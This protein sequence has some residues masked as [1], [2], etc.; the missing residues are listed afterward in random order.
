MATEVLHLVTQ[1]NQPYGSTRR[2]CEMCGAMCWPGM[3]GSAKRWTD[4]RQRWTAA[5]DNCSVAE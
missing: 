2:C 5:R 3:E 1:D 4:D